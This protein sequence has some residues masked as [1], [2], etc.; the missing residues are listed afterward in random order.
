MQTFEVIKAD[1]P[2]KNGR[3]YPL[4]LLNKIVEDTKQKVA[5]G[6]LLGQL[7]MSDDLV[8]QFSQVSH[9]ITDLRVEGNSMMVDIEVLNTPKGK[10]LMKLLDSN[11]VSFRTCGVG[12]IKDGVMQDSYKL[13]SINAVLNDEAS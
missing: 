2:N 5:E 4:A 6:G 11:S 8:V 13:A 12:G 7:G 10:E 9:K 1:V 3:I